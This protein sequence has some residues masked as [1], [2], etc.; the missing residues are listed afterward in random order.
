M[1]HRRFVLLAAIYTPERP[2]QHER[3]QQA[4]GSQGERIGYVTDVELPDVADKKIP[5]YR[6]QRAP[7]HVDRWRRLP[8]A[9]RRSEW[10]REPTPGHAVREV[11]NGVHK[12]SPPEEANDIRKP[13]HDTPLCYPR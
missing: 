7:E 8:L 13:L 4:P 3:H 9:G 1:G 6:I 11:W 2:G 10:R 5:D 12:K